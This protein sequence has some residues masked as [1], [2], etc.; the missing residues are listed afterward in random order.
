[1]FCIFI[2]FSFPAC[3]SAT[4]LFLPQANWFSFYASSPLVFVFSY[5]L[6]FGWWQELCRFKGLLVH[7]K[8]KTDL[9]LNDELQTVQTVFKHCRSIHGL[10]DENFKSHSLELC[11]SRLESHLFASE[12]AF[13]TFAIKFD[14]T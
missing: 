11:N 3:D 6:Y 1:M 2:I 14:V 13:Y 7:V 8:E 10:G 12:F 5:L 4:L 9:I